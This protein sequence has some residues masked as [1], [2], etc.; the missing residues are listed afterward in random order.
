M[1]N[2]DALRHYAAM[3]DKEHDRYCQFLSKHELE[4]NANSMEA[5]FKR[6]ELQSKINSSLFELH[7][8]EQYYDEQYC[9]RIEARL[10]EECKE[11]YDF[12]QTLAGA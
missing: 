6:E 10:E 12:L 8:A 7:T 3:T 5:W 1:T 4:P 2:L 9:A 11:L